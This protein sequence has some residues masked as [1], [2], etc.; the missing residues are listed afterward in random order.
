MTIK[1]ILFDLGET[2]LNYG[3][4]DVDTLFAQGAHLTYDHLRRHNCREDA[5][6]CFAAYNRRHVISIKWHYFC[7]C[8][9]SREFDCM[10]LLGRIARAMGLRLDKEQLEEL[11]W[12]W[13]KPLGDTAEIEPDLHKTLQVLRDIPLE[14][15]IISNTFLPAFVLDRHLQQFELLEFFPVRQ[16]SSVTVFRKPH[17]RIYQNTLDRLGVSADE[18]VMVGD[19]FRED[20]KG[21]ARLGIT[22]VFKRGTANKNK[23]ISHGIPVIDNISE[24]PDL[25][26]RL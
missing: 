21:P 4:V 8:V 26:P 24:L 11:T 15:A 5:L 10:A 6:P 22:G 14:L 18:A 12:L 17:R 19:K 3:N 9:T 23:R 7:S 1:A 25:I 20:I 2:I 13:Y 16:Y